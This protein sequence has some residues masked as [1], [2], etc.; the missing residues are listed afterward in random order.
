[1]IRRERGMGGLVVV[2]VEEVAG[3]LCRGSGVWELRSE[4]VRVIE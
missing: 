1:L 4:W 3:G 2:R